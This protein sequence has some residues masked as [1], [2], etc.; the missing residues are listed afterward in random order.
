VPIRTGQA[1]RLDGEAV[2]NLR[3][4]LG[5]SQRELGRR[6][7]LSHA[8]ISRVERDAL[9]L[10][11]VSAARLATALGVPTSG[12]AVNTASAREIPHLDLDRSALRALR[13]SLMETLAKVDRALGIETK[14]DGPGVIHVTIEVADRPSLVHDFAALVAAEGFSIKELRAARL[15]GVGE[16]ACLLDEVRARWSD[17]LDAALQQF[18]ARE[19]GT[20]KCF[21]YAQRDH[22]TAAPAGHAVGLHNTRVMIHPRP[23]RRSS[24]SAAWPSGQPRP[25]RGNSAFIVSAAMTASDRIGLVRDVTGALASHGVSLSAV[26]ASEGS[27]GAPGTFEIWFETDP[28]SR[29]RAALLER[30]L[31]AHRLHASVR[32]QQVHEVLAELR[33]LTEV[34]S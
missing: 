19:G 33:D 29:S 26:E 5:V 22:V 7:R 27:R 17:R 14:V 16:I 18:L 31:V 28:M 6:C 12:L 3:R 34:A 10:A 23:R 11:P 1:V 4:H 13:G 24:P 15:H 21:V 2:R 20:L 30:D 8:A 25:A 9:R 32:F